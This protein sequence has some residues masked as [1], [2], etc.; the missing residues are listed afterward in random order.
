M[1][2]NF[3]VNIQGSLFNID[4][5]AFELL[6]GYLDSIRKHLSGTEGAAEIFQDIEAR[7]T[8]MLSAHTAEQNH[9]VTRIDVE[10]VIA[11]MGKPS[12]IAGEGPEAEKE[13]T[14][15]GKARP[16]RLFRDID[17]KI[18][19]GV[20]SG[21]AAYF[22]TDA[23]WFRLGFIATF[24]FAGPL[25]YLAFWIAM[26]AARSTAEKLEMK[27]EPVNVANI[28]KSI[29]DEFNDIADRLKET[30]NNAKK[31]GG[32]EVSSRIDSGFQALGQ[33]LVRIILIFVGL[34]LLV[35]GLSL[36][37]ALIGALIFPGINVNQYMEALSL[38]ELLSLIYTD[39]KQVGLLIW[40]ISLMIAVPALLLIHSAIKLIFNLKYKAH[41]LGQIAGALFLVGLIFTVITNVNLAS[42]FRREAV[43]RDTHTIAL[44]EGRTLI[45]TTDNFDS[46]DRGEFDELRLEQSSNGIIC[47]H[48]PE[49]DVRKSADDSLHVRVIRKSRGADEQQASF[50]S[51]SI[52]YELNSTDSTIY[53]PST[54]H[55]E[56]GK[57]WR[58]PQLKVLM[59]V[60]V[61]SILR[62]DPAFDEMI[63]HGEN[64]MR[65]PASFAGN[66]WIMT[67]DKGLVRM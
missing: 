14:S 4:E 36:V 61:G 31:K 35:I 39:P 67:A 59:E 45:L 44:P 29:R 32:S 6:N 15:D 55:M 38:N 7:I 48:Y 1:K 25:V 19:G 63:D 64:W 2:R 11:Q 60:P 62:V 58:Y 47:R 22:N 8:E 28:E 16:K 20:G 33:V 21:M 13:S 17:N 40:G 5:D 30:A 43:I 26:P 18:I 12:E 27:G 10:K 66:S 9:V 65:F 51:R 3:T 24:F 23:I 53:L 41:Y 57:T 56:A 34:L 54:F 37:A 50:N 42:D 52:V 46:S 49:L